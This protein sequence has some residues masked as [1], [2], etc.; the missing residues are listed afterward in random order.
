MSGVR[1]NRLALSKNF[2]HVIAV[3]AFHRSP[4][5]STECSRS[6]ISGYD[7]CVTSSHVRIVETP[8]RLD[9]H[10]DTSFADFGLGT[11]K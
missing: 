8:D 10:P 3:R 5:L 1:V 9:K 7:A 4:A 11:R 2:K 6:A